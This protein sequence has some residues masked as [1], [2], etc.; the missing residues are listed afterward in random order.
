MPPPAEILHV[1]APA[2]QEASRVLLPWRKRQLSYITSTYVGKWGTNIDR[3]D[4]RGEFSSKDHSIKNF[5][6]AQ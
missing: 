1:F 3:P 5:T 2:E 4:K 6:P